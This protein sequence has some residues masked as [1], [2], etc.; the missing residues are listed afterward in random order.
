MGLEQPRLHNSAEKSHGCFEFQG[1]SHG[2]VFRSGLLK[3]VVVAEMAEPPSYHAVLKVVGALILRDATLMSNAKAQVPP[4][5]SN[6]LPEP[7]QAG[8]HACNRLL[9]CW[10]SGKQMQINASR[11]IEATFPWRSN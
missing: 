4:L 7:D 8:S 9:T 10:P 1:I 3:I 6:L 5:P 11:Q 2:G